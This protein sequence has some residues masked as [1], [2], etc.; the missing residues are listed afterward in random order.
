MERPTEQRRRL[1]PL[2]ALRA[3]EAAARHQNFTRA[4]DELSVTPGAVSQQIQTLEDYIGGALFKR[5]PKGLL[6]TD[7][8]HIA[9]PALG[10]ASDRLRGTPRRPPPPAH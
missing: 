2:N 1:P 6:L 8:A 5:P 10:E 9:L 3:F 7:P 4:A